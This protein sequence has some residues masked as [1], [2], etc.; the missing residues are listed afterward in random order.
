MRTTSDERIT[1][2]TNS[3]KWGHDTLHSLLATHAQTR[4]DELA[5]KDAP[6]REELTGSSPQALTWLELARASDNLANQF[7]AAGLKAGDRVVIQLP[8]IV[9][10][11]VVYYALS[12]MGVIASPVPIQYGVFELKKIVEVLDARTIISI[13]RFRTTDL[14]ADV[15]LALPELDVLVFGEDLQL[16]SSEGHS[17]ESGISDDPNRVFS[18][19]WTSGTTGT[20]KGVPRSHNMWMSSGRNTAKAS[21]YIPGDKLLCPFPMVNM[22]ALG[23]FLFSAVQCGCSIVLHHP[24]EPELFLRQMQDESI[25][26]T[27]APPALLNQLAKNPDMWRQ[28]DFSNLRSI[29]SGSAPLTPW[30]IKTFSEEFGVEVINIYGSNEGIGLFITPE[31]SQDPDVRA[32]MF[33]IPEPGADLETRVAD[34]VS[35]KEMTEFGEIGELLVRG[36]SV[37]DGYF[38]HDNEDMFDKDG[39]FKTGDLVEICSAAGGSY[40]IAGRCKDI[41]NRGGMKISPVELDVALEGHPDI[42]EAAVCA[43]P[44]TRLG[45]KICAC[46]VMRPGCQAMTLEDTTSHLLNLGM[47]KFKLPERIEFYEELPR[48]ALGKVQR[49][50]LQ[51]NVSENEETS[52]DET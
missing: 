5:V 33:P 26:Y 44:D 27:I 15:R 3:G 19:C 34:P 14:A 9:E 18:I 4:P 7:E 1:A 48:N 49:F 22:A 37:F 42:T 17:Y 24:L 36:A 16:D 25:N 35:G 20:P 13:S 47:A 40:K 6:N 50:V 23:G 21:S 51:E 2:L 8:N 38:E 30:M 43:Y 39:F 31:M 29:G 32:S 45:E 28:F 46:I 41:I 12:K 11:L 52:G 10:L